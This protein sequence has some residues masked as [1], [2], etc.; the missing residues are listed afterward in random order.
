M[1]VADLSCGLL[2]V[3]PSIVSAVIERWPYGMIW[4]QVSGIIHSSSVTTSM[5]TVVLVS[6]DRYFAIVHS[7]KY[8]QIVTLRRIRIAI[9]VMWMLNLCALAK[10]DIFGFMY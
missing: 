4:C 7:I 6:L 5:Y 2:S 8:R 10:F 9:F 1:G 3:A